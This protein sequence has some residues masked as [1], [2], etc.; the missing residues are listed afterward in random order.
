LWSVVSQSKNDFV[1]AYSR[2][3]GRWIPQLLWVLGFESH[4]GHFVFVMATRTCVC[5]ATG[6]FQAQVSSLMQ[7]RPRV[8]Y[9]RRICPV[10]IYRRLTFVSPAPNLMLPSNKERKWLSLA[11]GLF[12]FCSKCVRCVWLTAR[13]N[14]LLS[15]ASPPNKPVVQRLVCHSWG[16]ES[17]L[18]VGACAIF[19][20]AGALVLCHIPHTSDYQPLKGRVASGHR[21]WR[22][23]PRLNELQSRQNS[24]GTNGLCCVL[25]IRSSYRTGSD[26][27]LRLGRLK[28][29]MCSI[30][31]A[32][33]RK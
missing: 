32:T 20:T 15:G 16:L 3:S 2:R 1:L 33:R 6:R 14:P 11:A 17:V 21:V 23:I 27:P 25:T 12:T 10:V 4:I 8:N 19:R 28:D 24:Q 9:A 13:S 18:L 30:F 29:G 26:M 5:Y 7:K 22:F 31:F